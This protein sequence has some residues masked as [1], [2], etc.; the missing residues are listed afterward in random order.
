MRRILEPCANI[1]YLFADSSLLN[2][3]K[4]LQ[5]LKNMRC[6][7]RSSNILQ[8][9]AIKHLRH[10][11]K[12]LLVIIHEVQNIWQQFIPGALDAQGN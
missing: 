1:T 7:Q 11:N 12:H 5:R 3:A 6:K 10:L 4:T 8:I 2:F 9:R